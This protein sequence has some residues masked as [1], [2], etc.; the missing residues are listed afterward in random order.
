MAKTY[1]L[2]AIDVLKETEKAFLFRTEEGDCWIPF[3]CVQSVDLYLG[4]KRPYRVKVI[5]SFKIKY[6]EDPNKVFLKNLQE[7]INK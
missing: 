2:K 6:T 5:E 3:S 1:T 7:N 4:K